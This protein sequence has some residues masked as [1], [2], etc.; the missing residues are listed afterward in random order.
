MAYRER[1]SRVPGA[2]IWSSVSSGTE[3]RVLPDGC[4]DL[5]W[6]GR[7]IVVAGPDTHAHGFLGEPGSTLTG[8]RFAPGFAPRVL[9]IPAAELTDQRAPLEAL[10]A[11]DR[12]RRVTELLAASPTPAKTLETI[13]LRHCS[14]GDDE[15]ALIELAVSLARGGCTSAAIAARV[16]LSSRQLQR[17]STLAFGYGTKTLTRILRLQQALA[18]I[19]GGTR[20]VD[21]AVRAGYA[22]QSHLA[23]EVKD[24]AGVTLTQLM[25]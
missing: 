1:R 12:V 6:D 4:M 7:A 23:R 21:S 18:C 20:A 5:L 24:L 10:W 8:L 13:A 9:G 3:V 17:R 2:V 15:T 16:G 25:Q 11:P 19:R 14:P 22:D